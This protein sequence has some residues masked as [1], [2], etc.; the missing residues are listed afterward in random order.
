L[1]FLKI[2]YGDPDVYILLALVLLCFYLDISS[3][4]DVLLGWFRHS[5]ITWHRKA[6]VI[7][8]MNIWM[9]CWL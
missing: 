1:E 7:A 6:A 3:K 5:L 8:R 4:F 9:V 2:V